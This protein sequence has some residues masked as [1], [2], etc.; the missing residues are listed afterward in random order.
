MKRLAGAALLLLSVI[1]AGVAL[2]DP[3]LVTQNLAVRRYKT[4]GDNNPLWVP[5]SGT[6][7]YVD[8]TIFS[9]STLLTTQQIDT[10]AAFNLPAWTPVRCAEITSASATADSAYALLFS[11]RGNTALGSTTGLDSLL[12]VKVQGSWDGG[13]SWA[14]GVARTVVEATGANAVTMWYTVLLPVALPAGAPTNANICA[15]P[16]LRIIF[17]PG[18]GTGQFEAKVSYFA[19]SDLVSR[20][21]QLRLGGS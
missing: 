12:S 21:P 17:S 9:N 2:A 13:N 6:A 11:V 8:S 1:S 7:G 14:A 19:S 3:V 4:N 15:A 20:F 16:M 18:S 5:T 10:T